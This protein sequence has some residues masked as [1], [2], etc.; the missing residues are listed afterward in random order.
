MRGNIV[1]EFF[2]SRDN[3][4]RVRIGLI[5][6]INF[7]AQIFGSRKSRRLKTTAI[8]FIS[9][10]HRLLA[11]FQINNA[12]G[13]RGPSAQPIEKISTL[14]VRSAVQQSRLH[15]LKI[16]FIIYRIFFNNTEYSAHSIFPSREGVPALAGGVLSLR[17][18]GGRKAGVGYSRRGLGWLNFIF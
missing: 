8:F 9:R 17:R 12:Q 11:G 3:Y 2:P 1:A 10:K 15:C 7:R 16:I 4:F 5:G 18:R 6:E 14:F 13:A